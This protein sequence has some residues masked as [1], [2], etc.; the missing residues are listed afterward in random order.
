[1]P[2]RADF[3]AA[4]AALKQA[5]ADATTRVTNDIQTLRNELANGVL[6]TD[7]DLASIQADTTAIGEIDPAPAPAPAA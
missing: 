3:D 5:V 6:V 4:I 1:M 7:A 2:T